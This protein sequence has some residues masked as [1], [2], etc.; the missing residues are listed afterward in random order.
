[1]EAKEEKEL[2]E[3]GKELVQIWPLET[4]SPNLTP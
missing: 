4:I 1:M 2:E 3:R